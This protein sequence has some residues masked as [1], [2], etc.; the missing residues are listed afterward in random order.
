MMF[1][2]NVLMN[3]ITY[4]LKWTK[5]ASL[6]FCKAYGLS[7]CSRSVIFSSISPTED[8]VVE[9]SQWSEGWWK[10]VLGLKLIFGRSWFVTIVSWKQT[11]WTLLSTLEGCIG[12]INFFLSFWFR[13]N[14]L[15]YSFQ[16]N[17]NICP[18]LTYFHTVTC[19]WMCHIL[20]TVYWISLYP[21]FIEYQRQASCT[22]KCCCWQFMLIFIFHEI[23]FHRFLLL[24]LWLVMATLASAVSPREYF[25]ANFCSL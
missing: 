11:E 3:E 19:Y 7:S 15:H 1:L 14:V 21:L 8:S 5:G 23:M 25:S 17:G 16:I 9:L 13:S 18:H 10:A 4:F 6:P 2:L 12:F 20:I 22:D 24:S